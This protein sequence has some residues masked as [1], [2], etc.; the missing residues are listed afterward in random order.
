MPM[1]YNHVDNFIAGAILSLVE[2]KANSE[3]REEFKYFVDFYH[4]C[5][6]NVHYN[7]IIIIK[8]AF[9]WNKYQ[10]LSRIINYTNF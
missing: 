8:L 1:T 6:D 7:I 2:R 4:L 5:G 9:F 3:F 10:S